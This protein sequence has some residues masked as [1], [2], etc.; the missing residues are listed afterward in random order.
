VIRIPIVDLRVTRLAVRFDIHAALL[1]F[2]VAV[3]AESRL[4]A[5]IAVLGIV[6]R[7]DGMDRDEIGPVRPGH[8]FPSPRKTP[9]QIRF[10]HPTLMAVQTEGLL[11]AIVAIVARLLGQQA[12]LLD[13]KGAVVAH[14]TGSAMAVLTLIKLA[15]FIFPVVGPGE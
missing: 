4:V 7:L 14:H 11:M 9:G 6:R 8:K 13:E 15:V 3:R 12:V 5:A 1:R 10:D 2:T